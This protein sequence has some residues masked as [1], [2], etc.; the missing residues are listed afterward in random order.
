[1]SFCL[2][3]LSNWENTVQKAWLGLV[4]IWGG[5]SNLAFADDWQAVQLRGVVLELDNGA[6]QQLRR[7]DVVSDD[8]IIKTLNGRATFQRGQEVV[9]M[10]ANSMIQIMDRDGRSHTTVVNHEGSIHL[11]V[12]A[13]NV[14]H[15]SVVT[16]HLAA[17]VKGTAFIVE[18]GPGSSDLTV[19]RGEVLVEDT[20]NRT[21]MTVGT[22]EKV[23]TGNGP[24]RVTPAETSAAPSATPGAP[25]K[26]PVAPAQASAA[27]LGT[28]AGLSE[29]PAIPRSAPVSLAGSSRVSEPQRDLSPPRVGLLPILEELEQIIPQVPGLPGLGPLVPGQGDDDEE[30]DEDNGGEDEEDEDEDEDEDDE[31]EDDDED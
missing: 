5:F 2:G 31:D 1:M 22:G 17:V 14:Y 10:A 23:E 4:V 15:F 19:T 24:A 6:W 13:R 7:G 27:A 25:M 3:G 11:D 26:P 9:E 20:A 29:G 12:D 8:R 16:P 18:T 30:E 21:R 28:P